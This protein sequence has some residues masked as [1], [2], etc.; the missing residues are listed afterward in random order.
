[1]HINGTTVTP[2]DF[3]KVHTEK[4]Y[5]A[6]EEYTGVFHPIDGL[7]T[8][9]GLTQPL[10]YVLRFF[11]TTPSWMI[12]IGISFVSRQLMSRR[13]TGRALATPGAPAAG[14]P[15]RD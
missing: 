4:T 8:K 11:S 5:L 3:V 1:M 10:G 9:L 6:E 15:K 12:M 14:A 13:M 2:Q 7:V